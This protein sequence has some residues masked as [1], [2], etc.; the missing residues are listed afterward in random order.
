MISKNK[1]NFMKSILTSLIFTL[2][3]VASSGQES[4]LPISLKNF[5]VNK[6][7]DATVEVGWDIIHQNSASGYSIEHSLDSKTWKPVGF[8]PSIAND[9]YKTFKYTHTNPGSGLNYYRIHFKDKDEKNNYSEVKIVSLKTHVNVSLWP[10]PSQDYLHIQC[11]YSKDAYTKAVIFSGTGNKVNEIDLIQGVN[12][13]AIQKL[14]PGLYY[15]QLSGASQERLS[16]QFV[17]A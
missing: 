1:T 11:N 8:V 13:I 6:I 10:N 9:K 17:K 12:K 3:C 2:S 16:L 5:T 4:I 15:I 14:T 7:K